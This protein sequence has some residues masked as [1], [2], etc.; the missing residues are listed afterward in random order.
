MTIWIRLKLD[1]SRLQ[2]QCISGDFTQLLELP[3]LR[4]QIGGCFQS[5]REAAISKIFSK[6]LGK[7][8]WQ[9]PFEI[10]LCENPKNSYVLKRALLASLSFGLRVSFILLQGYG[11]VWIIMRGEGGGGGDG[12]LWRTEITY[13]FQVACEILIIIA[14]ST[15]NVFIII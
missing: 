8:T 5:A 14:Y 3:Q 7:Q 13:F 6:Y 15:A 12:E 2:Q 9:S 4:T 10:K 1:Q 11:K